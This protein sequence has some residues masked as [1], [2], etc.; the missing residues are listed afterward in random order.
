VAVLFAEVQTVRGIGSDGL[1]P[2]CRSVSSSCVHPD[3]PHLGLGRS[4]ITQSVVFFAAN[5]DLASR[6]GPHRG[7]EIL[8][9]C[10]GVDRPPKTPLVDV[11]P[12]KMKI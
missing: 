7:G 4:A 6:E 10:L 1:R 12:K 9:V 2:G 8:G 3:G 11:E 5:L